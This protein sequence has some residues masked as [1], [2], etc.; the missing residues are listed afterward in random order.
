MVASD[1]LLVAWAI[2][3]VGIVTCALACLL[4]TVKRQL[5]RHLTARDLVRIASLDCP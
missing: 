4:R 2:L 5:K 3:C 1:Q